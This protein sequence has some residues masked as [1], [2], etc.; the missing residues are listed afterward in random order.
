M[1]TPPFINDPTVYNESEHVTLTCQSDGRP[2]AVAIRWQRNNVTIS[3]DSQLT[4][5]PI[6]QS[7][8]GDYTCC[9]VRIIAG[10]L[11]TVCDD[12]TITVQCE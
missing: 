3:P 5:N 12:F 7:D 11:I 6:Q 2:S 10:G 9:I 1:N 8:A 4:F